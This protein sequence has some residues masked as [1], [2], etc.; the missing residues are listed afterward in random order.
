MSCR[1]AHLAQVTAHPRSRY[2]AELVGTNLFRGTVA[3]GVLRLA[4][5]GSVVVPDATTPGTAFASIRPSAVALHR[6]HPEGSARNA[7]LLTLVDV[8]RREDR[9]RVRLD[10]TVPLVAELTLAGLGALRG[11][12]R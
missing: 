7:W 3:G 1:R 4:G 10:G 9:V 5:G 12:P 6:G 2:V 8:D 11:R